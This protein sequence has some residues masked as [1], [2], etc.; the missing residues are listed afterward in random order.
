[1][2]VG[3][4]NLLSHDKYTFV[5]VDHP[6]LQE[7]LKIEW[8]PE[9]FYKVY[10]GEPWEDILL[11]ALRLKRS[12]A[13]HKAWIEDI[14][15]G[16]DTLAVRVFTDLA[17]TWLHHKIISVKQTLA[18]LEAKWARRGYDKLENEIELSKVIE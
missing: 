3:Q 10:Q 9:D 5:Y 2:T 6:E 8:L 4:F 11:A 1:M 15:K 17:K 16:E 14:D 13:I 7:S 18:S 12:L